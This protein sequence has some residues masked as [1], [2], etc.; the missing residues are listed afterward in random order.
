MKE[1]NATKTTIILE[2][3]QA[4]YMNTTERKDIKEYLTRVGTHKGRF[5]VIAMLEK[6]ARDKAPK[7][8][9]ELQLAAAVAAAR[10]GEKE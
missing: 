8:T 4:K 7:S 3:I 10:E 2:N 6:I 9:Q 1:R 5:A